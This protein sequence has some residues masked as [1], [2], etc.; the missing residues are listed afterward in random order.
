MPYEYL[1][2]PHY[3]AKRVED[4][5]YQTTTYETD[6]WE[7]VIN[8]E[9]L[10][11]ALHAVSDQT[12]R[13]MG[14]NKDLDAALEKHLKGTYTPDDDTTYCSNVRPTYDQITKTFSFQGHYVLYS[15]NM[16]EIMSSALLLYRLLCLFKCQVISYGPEGYK[17][18]WWITLKH[19]QSG[20]ILQFGEWKGA[21]GIWTKFHNTDELPE[22]YK[23]DVLDLLNVIY[24]ENCPH[25]YDGCVAGSV[26]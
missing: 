16:N 15:G 3:S 17:S 14:I 26:A 13:L 5:V 21:A 7:P 6:K 20:E 1:I 8:N 18:V 19:K 9:L 11:T 23:Q 2:Q 25:P 22:P 4:D 10:D 24:S 12:P